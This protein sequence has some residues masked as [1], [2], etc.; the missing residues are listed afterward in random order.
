MG[1]K[2]YTEE[3]LSEALESALK[4]ILKLKSREDSEVEKLMDQHPCIRE[5]SQF[6]ANGPVGLGLGRIGGH[7]IG[8]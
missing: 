7:A 1:F 6:G 3:Q 2:G 5:V 8:D 4:L